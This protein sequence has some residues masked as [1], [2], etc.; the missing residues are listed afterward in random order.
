[1]K[2]PKLGSNPRS[3][4]SLA[5][6]I[7]GIVSVVIFWLPVVRLIVSA[8]AII[9]GSIAIKRRQKFGFMGLILGILSW[10]LLII[11]WSIV[12]S[13]SDSNQESDISDGVTL[14]ESLEMEEFGDVF[15]STDGSFKINF[16]GQ[17]NYERTTVSTEGNGLYIDSYSYEKDS[18]EFYDVSYIDFPPEIIDVIDEPMDILDDAIQD[19]FVNEGISDIQFVQELDLQGYPGVHY[20]ASDS[21]SSDYVDYVGYVVENRMYLIMM[22]EKNA[23]FNNKA[24]ERFI[25]TFE[26][27]QD[28]QK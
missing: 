21:I 20:K 15:E 5:G 10:V 24:Y 22:V 16:P 11:F 13:Q 8:L 27:I 9:F 25:G 3:G 17:P 14:E 23:Y 19:I 1:M 2:K 28:E 6:L 18:G 26:L 12:I 7:L 4:L